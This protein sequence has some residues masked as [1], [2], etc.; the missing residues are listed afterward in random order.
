MKKVE[1]LD[2]KGKKIEDYTLSKEIFGIEPNQSVL[3]QYI[4]VYRSNQRQGTSKVKT[5]S[6]VSGGGRKPWRQKGTGRARVGSIRSP[7]WRH[8]GIT[9]GPI[10]KDWTKKISKNLKRLALKSALSAKAS[11]NKIFVLDNLSIKDPST[12]EV[13]KVL[14]NFKFEGSQLV[15]LGSLDRNLIKSANNIPGVTT[16]QGNSLSAYDVLVNKNILFLKDGLKLLEET[17][18]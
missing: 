8:G 14:N 2:Q 15:V 10:P 17:Y 11:K 5:R 7:I 4:H 18:K 9:H 1:V 6:E 12:K 16:V 3:L 13:A